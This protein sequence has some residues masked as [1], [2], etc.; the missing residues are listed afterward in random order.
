MN[1]KNIMLLVLV[2]LGFSLLIGGVSAKSY[3]IDCPKNSSHKAICEQT[4]HND[5]KGIKKI[6][7]SY[8]K[9]YN[10]VEYNEIQCFYESTPDK[11]QLWY[12]RCGYYN[13]YEKRHFEYV[14]CPS[15]QVIKTQTSDKCYK[16]TTLKGKIYKYYKYTKKITYGN[17]KT[18]ITTKN[19]KKLY[20]YYKKF[21]MPST[22]RG[23]FKT[24]KFKGIKLWYGCSGPS[25]KDY[26]V[27]YDD[28]NSKYE[29]YKFSSN[30]NYNYN[31][32]FYFW[33][34]PKYFTVYVRKY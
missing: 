3:E 26:S 18:N 24:T 34:K 12:Y 29:V 21:T 32:G 17:G 33:K 10:I 9:V 19:Y 4:I 5:Y 20:G 15:N 27:T 8:Y 30:T 22:A 11:K 28:I 31:G 2:L 23:K 25:F 14:K 1:K 16:S 6:N 7:G 13:D